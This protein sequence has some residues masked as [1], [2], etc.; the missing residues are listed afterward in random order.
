[1][2][3]IT[4]SLLAIALLLT[5][6][7]VNRT[8]P[9]QSTTTAATTVTTTAAVT[10]SAETTTAP[11]DTSADISEETSPEDT[12]IISEEVIIPEETD[13]PDEIL[14]DE[15]LAE[16]G[17]VIPAE[18]HPPY[19]DDE[20]VPDTSAQEDITVY[21]EPVK[22]DTKPAGIDRD[23]TYTSPEDVAEYIHTFGTLPDNFITKKQLKKLGWSGGD[24]YRYADGKSIGGDRFGNYEGVLP[25]GDYHECD[26]NYFGGKRGAERIV[27]S[28]EA[29]YY[30]NDHYETFTQLY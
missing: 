16:D 26:V 22:E 3:R 1:M 29:I 28:D 21:E 14:T 27:W 10:T 25:D 15:D 20:A 4:G 7:T 11:A 9:A 30:T 6:C 19:V 5:G 2:K 24:V 18:E 12:E 17:E 23:G 8:A 13:A